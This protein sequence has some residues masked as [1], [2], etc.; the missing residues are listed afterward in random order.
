MLTADNMNN[1]FADDINSSFHLNKRIRFDPN[2]CKEN[3][4]YLKHRDAIVS[5]NLHKEQE[6][7]GDNVSVIT[8]IS[9]PKETVKEKTTGIRE[10][11]VLVALL[12]TLFPV[13]KER[14]SQLRKKASNVSD[15][16]ATSVKIHPCLSLLEQQSTG[17]EDV[18]FCH[19]VDTVNSVASF[20]SHQDVLSAEAA[21]NEIVI[22]NC[23]LKTAALSKPTYGR[24]RLVELL[25]SLARSSRILNIVLKKVI[26]NTQTVGTPAI[27]LQHTSECTS[28]INFYKIKIE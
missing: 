22:E 24:H 10:N 12:N 6:D 14:N 20:L 19:I 18:R 2:E 27:T 15:Y 11:N 8:D 4:D 17:N 25:R 28:I 3:D 7:G 13:K 5:R 23:F 21:L 9:E 1:N 16:N 26:D